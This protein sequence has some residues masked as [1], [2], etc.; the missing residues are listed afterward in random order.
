MFEGN[1]PPFEEHLINADEQENILITYGTELS[2][3]S[4]NAVG[5]PPSTAR[6]IWAP[7]HAIAQLM[8]PGSIRAS[9]FNL[10]TA[11]LGS[12]S[13]VY[14]LCSY[15]YR[16]WY[17]ISSLCFTFIWSLIGQRYHYSWKYGRP[18]LVAPLGC[19]LRAILV[20]LVPGSRGVLLRLQVCH[21][22]TCH[23]VVEC[24]R[25]DD[26]IHCCRGKDHRNGSSSFDAKR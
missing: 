4:E 19:L 14:I 16:E 23:H 24:V 6:L 9:V 17:F 3:F 2:S 8:K 12:H 11:I 20:L 25:N 21:F 7:F 10:I 1:K 15:L 13:V 5:N 26:I 18:V 22:H